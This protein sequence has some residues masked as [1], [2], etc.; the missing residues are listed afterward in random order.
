M[1]KMK[2]FVIEAMIG[3]FLAPVISAAAQNLQSPQVDIV[4][5]AD[6]DISV[7]R[8]GTAPGNL[9]EVRASLLPY[10]IMLTNNTDRDIVGLAVTWTP[11]GGQPFGMQSESFGST[12][13][14]PIVPARGQAI[15][16]PDGFQRADLIQRGARMM[17]P[18]RP[19][20]ALEAAYH[21]TI[22]IDAI[23]FDGGLV[24]GPD[25][26]GLVDSINARAEAI[27][28][29]SQTVRSA[30]KDGKDVTATLQA[31]VP[32]RSSFETDKVTNW[33]QF[34]VGQLLHPPVRDRDW[35][36]M[37]MESL[38]KPPTFIRK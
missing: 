37:E 25:K 31:M 11:E 29:I 3:L 35:I 16:T 36:L 13:K 24:I 9:S 4:A 34:Y 17:P 15:L 32:P 18:A 33:M 20:P 27:A 22:N 28:R 38:P 23:I 1:L 12:T 2:P 14:S 30:M 6:P 7:Q 10:R 8:I 26:T 5:P 19:H 21:A